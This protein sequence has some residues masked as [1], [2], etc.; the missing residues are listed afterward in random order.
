MHMK[1]GTLESIGTSDLCLRRAAV[2]PIMPEP[3]GLNAGFS[4]F[5][6]KNIN[7]FVHKF[8]AFVTVV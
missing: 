4:N 7:E 3:D 1:N 8:Y 5:S 2:Y 6:K